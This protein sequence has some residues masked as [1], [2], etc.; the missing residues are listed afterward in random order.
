[1]AK[2]WNSTILLS[3]PTRVSGRS[4]IFELLGIT[5]GQEEEKANKANPSIANAFRN[6]LKMVASLNSQ[7]IIHYEFYEKSDV[8]QKILNKTPLILDP[9][10]PYNNLMYGF[11]RNVMQLF[12]DCAR[13]SLN[14]FDADIKRAFHMHRGQRKKV[15]PR[16][17]SKTKNKKKLQSLPP[18]MTFY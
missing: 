14:T 10:S 17:S 15:R 12:S 6:F 4:T 1:M 3:P 9:S 5:A 7:R 8:P 2:Y 18:T 11:P 16:E 13:E